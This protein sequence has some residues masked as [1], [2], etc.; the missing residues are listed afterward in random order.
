MLTRKESTWK[1]SEAKRLL[2]QD[3]TSGEIPLDPKEMEPAQ[4]Y[5]QRPEFTDFGYERFRK[6]L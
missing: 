5:P 2:L 1:N 3:L 6:N 4:V